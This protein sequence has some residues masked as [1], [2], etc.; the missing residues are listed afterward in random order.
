MNIN[1]KFGSEDSHKKSLRSIWWLGTISLFLYGTFK[2]LWPSLGK[3]SE[4]VAAALGIITL[5]VLGR[6]VRS[7]FPIW[8]LLA[9]VVVQLLSWV[10]GNMHHPEW[11]TSNPKIDRLGKLFLF[12]SFAWWLGGSTRKTLYLWSFAAVGFILATFTQGQ[13]LQEWISGLQG[14]RIDFNIRNAQHTA[15]FFGVV[16]LGLISFSFRIIIKEKKFI[17]W[18]FAL[19]LSF[20]VLCLV[21]LIVTQTRAIWLALSSAFFILG[22]VWLLFYCFQQR[23]KKAI[24]LK[25]CISVVLVVV[26]ASSAAFYFKDVVI[27][28]LN[29]ESDVI[30]LI[31]KGDLEHV[32][33]TSVGTRI[34]TWRAAGEWISE[35][36]LIGWGDKGR[37]LVI[38]QT[39]WLPESVRNKFGHLHNYFL[40]VLVAYG[41]LGL[42]VI[43]TLAVWVGHG[44]FQ[45]W[46]GGVMPGDMAFFGAAFFIYWMIINQ[47]ESY[48]SFGTGVYVH[49]II[50][51]GL[52]THIWRVKFKVKDKIE[53]E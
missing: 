30:S 24:P 29:H 53:R 34:Q 31:L 43:A 14:E 41:F 1:Y 12:I 18:R 49:N 17:G 26:I 40:E 6:G 27:K 39:E 25:L 52:V 20:T 45:A 15:M 16:F 8:L 33:Y 46:R 23:E 51:A 21:G 11:M 28:R 38:K 35:R 50:L 13:G 10:L 47:F 37:S 22:I 19:W 48:N 32:P 5:L 7:S 2:I 3:A 42:G 44:T 4:G 36:P 9:A